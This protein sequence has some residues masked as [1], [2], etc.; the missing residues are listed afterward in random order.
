[1]TW[2]K[3]IH[4]HRSSEYKL[5]PTETAM[6][7]SR[8][9]P[10]RQSWFCEDL[11]P[12]TRCLRR[13]WRRRR[14]CRSCL[15]LSYTRRKLGERSAL[16]G[17]PVLP[18]HP[19]ICSVPLEWGGAEAALQRGRP[20]P[21]CSPELINKGAH[22]TRKSHVVRTPPALPVQSGRYCPFWVSLKASKQPS[23]DA[24]SRPGK[25]EN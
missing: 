14:W 10:W 5:T 25:A 13:S 17:G 12:Q 9:P 1:M 11:Q 24:K 8:T 4:A 22:K 23:E 19:N 7:A 21:T 2:M 3:A 6:P 20:A 18:H 15:V 16:G